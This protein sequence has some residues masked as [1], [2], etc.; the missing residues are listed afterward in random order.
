MFINALIR[1]KINPKG[2]Q[3]VVSTINFLKLANFYINDRDQV[4]PYKCQSKVI[5]DLFFKVSLT[6][7]AL[8]RTRAWPYQCQSSCQTVPT[9]NQTVT[10][11]CQTVPTSNQ[12]VPTSCQTVP[13]SNKTVPTS[14]QTVPTS[15]QTAPTS[16][17]TAPTSEYSLISHGGL[18]LWRSGLFSLWRWRNL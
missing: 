7:I 17:Q 16:N 13:T 3:N 12:T 11:S 1:I 6:F 4:L 14:C 2:A 18:S 8:I 9:S 10:T 5:T 15:N